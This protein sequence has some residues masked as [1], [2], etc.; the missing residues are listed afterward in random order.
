MLAVSV[1]V[2]AYNMERYVER[3]VVSALRQSLAEIEV[4]VVDDASQ[5][6]TAALVERLAT[7][8]PRVRL[9]RLAVNGG[10]SAARNAAIA[11]ARGEW[12]A[13]LDADDWYAPERLEKLVAAGRARGADLV[14]DNLHYVMEGYLA[15]WQ[16]LFPRR[17]PSPFALS[18]ADILRGSGAGY[19]KTVVSIKP[20]FRRA[21]LEDHGIRYRDALRAGEDGE[22]LLRCLAR[23]PRVLVLREPMYHYL[24]R[25]SSV[26][27][28]MGAERFLMV[29]RFNEELLELYR[30]APEVQRWL[31]RSS[32]RI[33]RYLRMKDILAVLSRG[34]ALRALALLA[35]DPGILPH[36]LVYVGYGLGYRLKRRAILAFLP[37]APKGAAPPPD[38]R[39]WS[40]DS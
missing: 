34:R 23:T 1:V 15:P 10:L 17:G 5:D 26:S 40:L 14:A 6:G 13:V 22:I 32:D 19:P 28:G 37:K 33:D 7:T 36:L 21:F 3:A 29:K 9:I 18:P 38:A 12:I 16:T 25:R 27:H 11:E 2:P 35:R 4:L 24:V 30:E 31:R 8:D 20:M 39:A